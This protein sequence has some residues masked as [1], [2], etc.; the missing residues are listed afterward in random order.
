MR[1]EGPSEYRGAVR[2]ILLYLNSLPGC[3][4]INI[5]GGIY[6]ERGTPDIIGS[7]R[8]EMFCFEVKRPSGGRTSKIQELRLRQWRAT[9]AEARVVRSLEEVRAWAR[10]KGID[11]WNT[12]PH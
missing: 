12:D 11:P 5:H 9:G 10:E 3:K 6:T 1:S 4:A 2:P 8:G 7:C